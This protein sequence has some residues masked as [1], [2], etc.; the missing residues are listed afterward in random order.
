MACLNRELCNT[1]IIV[2]VVLVQRIQIRNLVFLSA[3]E[4]GGTSLVLPLFAALA[5]DL[6]MTS[7]DS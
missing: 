2:V 1:V 4:G 6:H 5:C 7:Y 3:S